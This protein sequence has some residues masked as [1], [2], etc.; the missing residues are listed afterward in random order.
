MIMTMEI[1]RKRRW[2]WEQEKRKTQEGATDSMAHKAKQKKE[3]PASSCTTKKPAAKKPA[4]KKPA[5][6]KPAAK[7]SETEK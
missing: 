2:S 4:A 7:K 6:K 1:G 3:D 5:A